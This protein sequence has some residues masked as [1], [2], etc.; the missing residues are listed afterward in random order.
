MSNTLPPP[1]PVGPPNT[2]SRIE[3]YLVLETLEER[4]KNISQK[5]VN[6][7]AKRSKSETKIDIFGNGIN[8]QSGGGGV[9]LSPATLRDTPSHWPHSLGVPHRPYLLR[10]GA[11]AAFRGD[12]GRRRGVAEKS[13]I[14]GGGM[15]GNTST[16]GMTNKFKIRLKIHVCR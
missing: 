9:K 4:K 5:I 12:T 6:S 10:H 1:C 16:Y 14:G 15:V 3:K 13:A 7:H 8:L 11:W 2:F